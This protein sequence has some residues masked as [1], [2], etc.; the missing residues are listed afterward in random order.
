[1]AVLLGLETVTW[2]LGGLCLKHWVEGPR[3]S[4]DMVSGVIVHS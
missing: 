3:H 2:Y 4:I 1:M